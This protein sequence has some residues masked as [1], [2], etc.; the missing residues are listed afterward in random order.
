MVYKLVHELYTSIYTK[1]DETMTEREGGY[2]SVYVGGR[3]KLPP[4][5][6]TCETVETHR[7]IRLTSSHVFIQAKGDLFGAG[8]LQFIQL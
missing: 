1:R 5:L 6:A 3:G 8:R 7:W 2:V 4:S